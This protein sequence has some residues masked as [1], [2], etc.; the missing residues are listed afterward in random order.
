MQRRIESSLRRR[1][2]T[3]HVTADPL[4]PPAAIVAD[5]VGCLPGLNPRNRGLL[6]GAVRGL[7]RPDVPPFARICKTFRNR[8]PR[9]ASTGS[10]A[11]EPTPICRVGC[12][13]LSFLLPVT[14]EAAGSS[15]VDPR[16][17]KSALDD[18][19]RQSFPTTPP[20]TSLASLGLLRRRRRPRARRR[21]IAHSANNTDLLPLDR[22]PSRSNP[23][24]RPPG[25][26]RRSW[27]LAPRTCIAR[28]SRRTGSGDGA[29]VSAA[30]HPV[31]KLVPDTPPIIKSLNHRCLW[32]RTAC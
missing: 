30:T 7:S 31:A 2:G 23:R 14:P 24:H 5:N 32:T 13:V 10:Q 17:H 22:T 16:L 18:P 3:Q 4:T 26:K 12:G 15:P 9:S 11:G 19:S 1:E 27:R 8:R 21:V 25:P 6:V 29:Q 20:P 28:A